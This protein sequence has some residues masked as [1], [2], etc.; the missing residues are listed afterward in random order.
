MFRAILI[1]VGVFKHQATFY[2]RLAGVVRGGTF[3]LGN[4]VTGN[5]VGAYVS[6]LKNDHEEQERQ[7][8]FNQAEYI[9]SQGED[10]WLL[11]SKVIESNNVTPILS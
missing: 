1:N 6:F 10:Y 11:S 9:G 7:R 2:G 4:K 8:K 5:D 3:L